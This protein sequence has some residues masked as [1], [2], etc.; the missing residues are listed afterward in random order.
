[1]IDS[2]RQLRADA[3]RNRERVLSAAGELLATQGVDASIDEIAARAGVGVGTVYRNFPTKEALLR[4]LLAARMQPLIADAEA[5][6]RAADPGEAFVGFVRRLSEEF[7]DFKAMAD[8]MAASGFDVDPAKREAAA[9]LIDAMRA[10][11][12]RAQREG[13]VR[14]DVGLADVSAMMIGLGH[15]DPSIMDRAQRSRCVALVCD[16]LLVGARSLLPAPDQ[17]PDSR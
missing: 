4:A 10:L 6:A 12:E 7:G 11:F 16:S 15:A 8:A 13:R 17:P 1:M 14:P 2:E 9:P 5:A 3:R